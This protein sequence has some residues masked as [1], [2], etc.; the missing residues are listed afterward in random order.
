MK[1]LQLVA[2]IPSKSERKMTKNVLVTEC[3]KNDKVYNTD[4]DSFYIEKKLA[5]LEQTN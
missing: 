3:F 5:I 1:P 2:A 4:T